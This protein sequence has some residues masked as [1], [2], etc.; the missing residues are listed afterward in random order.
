MFSEVGI[1]CRHILRI[2]NVHCVK[3]ILQVYILSRWTK[4]A[5][6]PNVNLSLTHGTD[7]MF[8]KILEDSV[9][10]VQMTRKFNSVLGAS[11]GFPEARRVCEQGYD[12]IKQFLDIQRNSS[13][14]DESASR[15]VLDPPRSR[16]KGQRN[17]RKRSIV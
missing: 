5:I 4:A 9:W 13:V 6:L 1:F 8:G 7:N 14:L 15:T 11:A 17:T 3:C 12:S 16:P 2:Y 10:R